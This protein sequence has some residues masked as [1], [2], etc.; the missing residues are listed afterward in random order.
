MTSELESERCRVETLEHSAKQTA[1]IMSSKEEE[2]S[3]LA[4][5]LKE[6]EETN[7]R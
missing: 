6:A 7:D 2:I 3:E 5:L 1:R 4:R